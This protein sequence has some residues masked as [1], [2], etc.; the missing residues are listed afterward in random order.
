MPAGYGRP[1]FFELGATTRSSRK[2]TPRL[3]Q[4]VNLYV[5]CNEKD[6]SGR[7]AHTMTFKIP[8]G[9]DED[10]FAF[11]GEPLVVTFDRQED[12]ENKHYRC[13]FDIIGVSKTNKEKN[14]WEISADLRE[15]ECKDNEQ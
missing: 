4:P 5:E 15:I 13:V 2:K 3:E 9:D 11:L 7:I 12:G 10:V 8:I 1:S 14:I 6:G